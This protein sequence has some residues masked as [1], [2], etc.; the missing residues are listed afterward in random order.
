MT[1]AVARDA[2]REIDAAWK[3]D[4][5]R[6]IGASKFRAWFRDTA[7]QSLS[8][9]SVV[10]AVPTRVHE[11][12]IA[13]TYG[14]LLRRAFGAILGEGVE[15][16]LAIS[17]VHAGARAVRERLPHDEAGWRSLVLKSRRAPTL[18][19]FVP[20]GGNGFVVRLLEQM[21]H[22][23]SAASPPS[24]MLCG[25]AGAGKTHLLRALAGA[26]E[27]RAPGSALYTPVRRLAER[28]VAAIRTRDL[29]AVQALEADLD[30]RKLLLVD[31]VDDLATKPQTQRVL[32]RWFERAGTTARRFVAAG[33]THP[34]EL[35]G[36]SPRL[37]SRLLSGLVHRLT[38]PSPALRRRILVERGARAGVRP[39]D[40]VVDAVLARE[41][42]VAGAVALFDRWVA[43]SVRESRPAPVEWLAE[44]AAPASSTPVDE[45]VRRAKDVV[46]TYYG[47]AR[48]VLE[49][50]TK[51]P[52][53]VEARRVA[54]YLAHRASAA[55]LGTLAAA[56]GWKSHSTAGRAVADVQARREVDPGFEALVDGLLASL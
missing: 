21:L 12:W 44:M 48:S 22:G 42:S 3:A 38:V 16:E 30:G 33:R 32:E 11:T 47:T 17:E 39:P 24:V 52:T 45:V 40:A 54:L 28:H 27:G 10:L 55:P 15:V 9:R 35:D 37:R 4:V 19:G 31:D 1:H 53:T 36:L 46:A 51:H 13:F 20:E 26:F 49:R 7:V 23:N 34:R 50:A 41:P 56:F 8:G 5:R 25:E 18:E 6:E 43:V 2:L 14:A 29:G